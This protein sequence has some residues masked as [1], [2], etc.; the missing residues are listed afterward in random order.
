MEQLNYQLLINNHHNIS[1]VATKKHVDLVLKEVKEVIDQGE[2][3][4][5]IEELPDSKY[6]VS[7][8][9]QL[10]NDTLIMK[11]KG[12]RIIPLLKKVK[13]TLLRNLRNRRKKKRQRSRRFNR[14]A[15]AV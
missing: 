12:K 4:V 10:P 15:R 9:A 14:R 8:A 7:M 13:K 2:I 3:Q 11:K 6:A 5:K 1:P